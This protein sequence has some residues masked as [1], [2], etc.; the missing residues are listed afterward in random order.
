MRVL[1]LGKLCPPKE[2]GIEVF[3]YDLLEYLNSKG[4]RADL[5]C[6]GD[7]TFKENYKGFDFYSCKMNIKINSAPLS[8][9]F[10]KTF[11]E[12]EKKYDLIHVHSPNPLA[13]FISIFSDKKVV[14]HWHS[15]IVKQKLT[16]FL[17][18]PFQQMYL[19][20]ADK[21]I[22]T[23]PQY[24]NTSKQLEG[25]RDKGAIIPLGLNPRKFEDNQNDKNLKEE[26]EKLKNEGKKIV[27]SIGRLVEYKGF[28]YLVEAGKYINDNT[29]I[30][31]VGGGPLFHVLKEKV[32]NL[33]LEDKV[34]L[35][36]RADTINGYIKNC[37][38]FC[39]PSITRNE[40]FGLVLVEALYFGKPLITTDVYGSGM[41][42]VNQNGITGFVVPPRN[43][44]ALAEAINKILGDANLYNNF[45]QN[46]KERF[47]EFEISNIGNRIIDLYKEILNRP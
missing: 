44:I 38:I 11:K 40:A 5:L 4:I 9:D 46:A 21:I 47:K 30:V 20:K 45:S 7:K 26:F 31:I 16:Y 36:G 24:L 1:H 12:I 10:I 18:K 43:P 6:F 32:K 3:S 34:F 14:A 17:Y 23:S 28:E 8:W 2:G 33:E 39:L 15:D 22:C 29:A 41:N 13:E 19:K 27:L 25:F 42:Y 35:T 37:D